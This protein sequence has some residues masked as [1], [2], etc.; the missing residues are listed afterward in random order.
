MF[1][2]FK[3]KILHLKEQKK[4]LKLKERRL[5]RKRNTK[6]N[7]E[8]KGAISENEAYKANEKKYSGMQIKINP[9]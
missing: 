8:F 2:I 9:N 5:I 7:K 6:E 1:L 4:A 3:Q